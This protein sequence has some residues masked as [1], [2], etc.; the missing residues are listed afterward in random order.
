MTMESR[1]AT[2]SVF[3]EADFLRAFAKA[4]YQDAQATYS[5][6]S[7]QSPGFKLNPINLNIQGYQLLRAKNARGAVELFKLATH[8]EPRFG[9]AFD[10]EGEAYEAL[11]ETALAIAAYEK[12]VAV[13]SKQS[14]AIARIKALRVGG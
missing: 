10:S 2:L 14:N 1:P 8:I 5:K 11:G 6:M 13:D 9:N 3:G 4:G 12:A 7:A